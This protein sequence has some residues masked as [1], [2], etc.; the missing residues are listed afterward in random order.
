MNL[1]GR[2]AIITGANQGLGRTIA[3]HFVRDGASVLLVAR[4]EELLRRTATELSALAPHAGQRVLALKGDVACPESCREVVAHAVRELPGLCVLVNNAGIQGPIGRF[5]EVA[6]EDWLE[7]VR[8]N[9]LGTA[10]M[11]RG[12]IPHLRRKRYGKVINLSGGGAAAPRPRFSAYAATKAAVVRLTETLAC[13]LADA[14]VDV[15]AVAP[16]ALNTR[17]LDEVL[18]AGPEKAGQEGYAKALAQ[19]DQGGASPEQA[20]ALVTFLASAQTDGISGRL[21]SA[22]WD[23]WPRLARRREQLAQSDVY[24]LRRIMPEDRGMQWNCA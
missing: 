15:N 11:C 3:E 24:T 13:E 9:L 19:R 7:T 12:F 1:T 6:W 14:H 20:A 17:L 16:G 2:S 22:V 5:E 4:G 8:V 18:A 21:F 10:L 23:D